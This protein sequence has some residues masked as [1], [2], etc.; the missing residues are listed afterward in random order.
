MITGGSYAGPSAVAALLLPCR[1][2]PVDARQVPEDLRRS[3]VPVALDDLPK[4][5]SLSEA[6][7]HDERAARPQEAVSAG[8][9]ALGYFGASRP[10]HERELRLEVPHLRLQ[11]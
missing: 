6:H 5:G 2:H 10:G 11:G 1:D 7:F 3:V 9:D 4:R 8:D